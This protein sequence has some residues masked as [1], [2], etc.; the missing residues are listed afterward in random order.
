MIHIAMLDEILA[1][2]ITAEQ[3]QRGEGQD[4]KVICSGVTVDDLLNLEYAPGPDVVVLAR[5]LL[6]ADPTTVLAELREK[7]SARMIII[8]YDFATSAQVD[9]LR[10]AGSDV[11]LQGPLSVRT[12]RTFLLSMLF[13]D[14][15]QFRGR[16]TAATPPPGPSVEDG[17][18]VAPRF[19]RSVL[20]ALRDMESAIQCECPNHIA[21][22]V[23]RLCAFEGY[24]KGCENRDD[25]DAKMHRTLWFA[26][27]RARRIMED[28]L[29]QLMNHEGIVVDGDTVRR[30]NPV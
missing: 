18:Y 26:T 16:R 5:S 4:L 3:Q 13:E 24:A 29:Q 22:L 21:E 17:P 8:T 15:L 9:Q 23:E 20:L 19:S 14:R 30:L 12:L 7:L 11:V 10:R 27:A 1:K 2:A 6:P 25:K 28:A